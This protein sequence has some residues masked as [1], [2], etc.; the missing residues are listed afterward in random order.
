M[1]SS[2]PTNPITRLPNISSSRA[3]IASA[4]MLLTLLGINYFGQFKDVNPLKPLSEFP[5]RIG[6]WS[7]NVE[8]F[9]QKIYDV[10][11]VDDSF[12]CDYLRP[13]G[14]R[15]QLYIGF[16]NSQRE[17]EMI[18]SPKNCM[19]GSGWDI[20][21]TSV[22]TLTVPGGN[23][24]KIGIIKLILEKEGQKQMALYWFQSRGR[25]ISSEYWEKIY[26]VWDANFKHRT[27]GAFV[28]LI[29]PVNKGEEETT[30]LMTQFAIELFPILEQ[31][32][33]GAYL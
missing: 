4:M 29:A 22:E 17:G 13:D 15:I 20:T 31:Y 8:R 2:N 32:L 3:L 33:P 9:D 16:Y 11:G 28:R 14:K 5:T 25:I 27:D 23:P 19:P 24:G 6:S 12:L 30:K 21:N 10:L 1:N 7:G 18:H 26:L